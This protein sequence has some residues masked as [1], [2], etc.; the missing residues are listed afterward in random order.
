VVLTDGFTGNVMLKTTEAIASFLFRYLKSELTAGTLNKIGLVLLVPALVAAL[1]GLALLSPG[2]LR[3][4]PATGLRRIRRR[5]ADGRQWG[6]RGRP[7]PLQRQSCQECG[8]A[9][10]AGG[11]GRR[12]R[13]DPHQPQPTAPEGTDEP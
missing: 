13:R 8:A 5:A 4:A 11:A 10:A 3:V 9:G 1:P 6:G 7:W 12:A 2:L